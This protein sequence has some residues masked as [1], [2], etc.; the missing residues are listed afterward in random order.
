MAT[1][2]LIH[3][4]QVPPHVRGALSRWMLE[5]SPGLY[6]GTLSGKVRDEL[7]DVISASVGEGSAVLVH[8]ADTEQRFTMLTSG[9]RRRMPV[10][11]DGAMVVALHPD[12]PDGAYET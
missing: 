3:T 8:T 2:T 4:T 11:L 5:P 6:V 10:D 12:E 7:W 1:L 9:R